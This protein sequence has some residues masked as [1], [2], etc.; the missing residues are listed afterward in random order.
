MSYISAES[1]SG[2]YHHGNDD[3]SAVEPVEP[4]LGRDDRS[5]PK[6]ETLLATELNK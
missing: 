4:F 3:C 2:A 5:I 6:S 1:E